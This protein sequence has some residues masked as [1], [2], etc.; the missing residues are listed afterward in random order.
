M[1]IC[2]ELL[3]GK[4]RDKTWRKIKGDDTWLKLH[5]MLLDGTEFAQDGMARW[6]R[7]AGFDEMWKVNF[8]FFL[9]LYCPPRVSRGFLLTLL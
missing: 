3:D 4:F 1:D 6:V 8:F 7:G 5:Y 2:K 9:P